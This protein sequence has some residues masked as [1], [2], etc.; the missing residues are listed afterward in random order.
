M[1]PGRGAPWENHYIKEQRNRLHNTNWEY[2]RRL[3]YWNTVRLASEQCLRNVFEGLRQ[4][5]F[6]IEQTPPLA[7]TVVE[8]QEQ[9]K[10]LGKVRQK[11]VDFRHW[12]PGT[13]QVV[14]WVGRSSNGRGSARRNRERVRERPRI[15]KKKEA[16]N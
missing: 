14:V 5:T 9:Q 3:T 4:N 11:S 15:P 10:P 13:W 6:E 16:D 7:S 8:L 12:A 2:Y 1:T